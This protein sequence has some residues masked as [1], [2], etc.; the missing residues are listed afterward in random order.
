M[1]ALLC[2]KS[3]RLNS[4]QAEDGI[5]DLYVTGVQTCAI[6]RK[7]TRLNSSHVEGSYAA[8][9]LK[10]ALRHLGLSGNELSALPEWLG[11]LSCLS[12]M[13]LS[14]TRLTTLTCWLFFLTGLTELFVAAIPLSG[15]PE[16]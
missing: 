5:R 7:S 10:T 9:C 12:W 1:S 6:D 3:T 16:S 14:G 13:E 2:G 11:N 8:F 4:S 15:L